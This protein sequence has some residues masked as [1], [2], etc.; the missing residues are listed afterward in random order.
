MKAFVTGA[1]SGI[2]QALA[3]RLGDRYPGATLGLTARRPDALEQ[4][5]DQ[6]QARR[7]VAQCACYPLDVTNFSAL[8]EAASAFC[9]QFG[10]PDIV[11]ANAGISAGTALGEDGDDDVFRRI[12]DVNV[13]GLHATLDAF[14]PAMRQR[15]SGVLVG[16]GSVAG[17]RGLPGAAAYSASKAAVRVCLESMRVE[18]RGSGVEVVTIAPGYI[19]TPM[20]EKNAYPMPFLMPVDRF[21]DKA[22]DAIAARRRH[23]VIPWQMGWVARGLHVLPAA[24]FDRLFAR[25]PRKSRHGSDNAG[26]L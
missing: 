1:S 11:I 17:V 10:P 13:N 12:I 14:V 22:L 3:T 21:A 24:L 4:L 18:L 23:V 25:A 6:L 19:D 8:R 9:E 20:T 2:G 7:R 16:I 15:G 26:P 5:A